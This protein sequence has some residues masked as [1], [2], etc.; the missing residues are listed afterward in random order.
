[1]IIELEPDPVLFHEKLTLLPTFI[2]RIRI[3][4]I[5]FLDLSL[6]LLAE[7]C[8]RFRWPV[9]LCPDTVFADHAL[10]VKHTAWLGALA[11]VLCNDRVK[12]RKNCKPL[13]LL[14]TWRRTAAVKVKALGHWMTKWGPL[15]RDHDTAEKEKKRGRNVR[16]CQKKGD[17][18]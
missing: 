1:M 4:N 2:F 12:L 11:K 6:F 10:M 14:L 16:A 17:N 13:P 9:C 18:N 3:V 5:S 8:V 15:H 7:V